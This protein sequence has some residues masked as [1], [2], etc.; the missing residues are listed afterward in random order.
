LQ[1]S[2]G[3]WAT[4]TLEGE[5]TWAI[6]RS[7]HYELV[8][9]SG[10]LA[11]GNPSCH[12][13]TFVSSGSHVTW[14][15][16]SIVLEWGD[17]SPQVEILSQSIDALQGSGGSSSIAGTL[18]GVAGILTADSGAGWRF[19]RGGRGDAV[20][21]SYRTPFI[22]ADA[23]SRDV[24]WLWAGR[25]NADTPGVVLADIGAM[26]AGASRARYLIGSILPSTDDLPRTR[27]SIDAINAAL[28]TGYHQRYVDLLG[29]LIAAASQT[30]GDQQDA[31]AGLVP[32]SLRADG[33]HLNDQ[34]YAVVAAAWVSATM[35]MGW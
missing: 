17:E 27:E 18:A 2:G 3:S 34:G 32:R 10:N 22:P 7:G 29:A 20:A 9:T 1:A 8:F 14:S 33:L 12:A 28:A 35:A 31:A 25:N 19:T 6:I 23:V 11:T 21:V 5:P 16:D 30:V 13:I 24:Q 26:A 4:T 15:L